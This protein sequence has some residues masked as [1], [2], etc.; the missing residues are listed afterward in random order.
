VIIVEGYTD[1]ISAHQAGIKNVVA[2]LGTALT[3]DHVRI[4]ARLAPIALLCFDA[5]SAGLK[6]AYRAGELFEANSIEVKVLDLP[7]GEDPDSLIRAG[8]REEFAHAVRIHF[9]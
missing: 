2:P 6:A 9:H 4:L 7:E 3:D 8:R 5:D 1:V